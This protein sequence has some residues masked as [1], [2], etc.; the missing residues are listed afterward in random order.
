[1]LRLAE[2]GAV[3]LLNSPYGPAEVWDHLPGSVQAQLIAKRLRFF[4]IDG[5]RVAREAGMGGRV[6][7]VMQTCFF[8]I[9]GV[10][11]RDEAIAAIKHAIEKTYGKRGETVVQKNWA[12]VDSAL[13]HLSE[14]PVPDRVTSTVEMRPAVPD[15]AP[16]FVRR[17]TAK[18]IAD[19]GDGLPVS[20]LPADGTY[21]TGT[22]RWEKRNIALEI[23]VWDEALCI[24]CG[25]CV[26]VCPHAVIRAKVYPP[27][28][29]EG[30]PAGFK[31]AGARWRESATPD[32]PCR[33]RPRTAPAAPSASRSV[34]PKARARSVTR[35][36]T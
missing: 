3:F 33:S 1:M 21:P 17:V 8:A 2:P 5:N 30:A 16:E 6:N 13:E 15:E 36:S 12:A 34:R 22:A 7:T 35:P 4:V 19:E 10:L 32:S 14:V 26:L 28:L 27:A 25:K 18:M 24:Q 20:A 29:L 31:S 9:S 11:P 23:P